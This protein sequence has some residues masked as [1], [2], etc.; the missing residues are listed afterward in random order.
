APASKLYCYEQWLKEEVHLLGAAALELQHLYRAM[1]F[2]EANKDAIERA[3]YFRMADLLNLDVE[4]IFYDTTSLHFEVDDEDRGQG[5]RDEV[6]GSLA[7]G[8][9]TYPA[10]RK[11][12]HSKNGRFDAPQIV[13]GLA[14]TRDGFPVRHWIFPG[15]TVDVTTVERVKQD[16]R[17]WVIGAEPRAASRSGG[18]AAAADEVGEAGHRRGAGGT[19]PGAEIVPEREAELLAGLAEAEEGVAAVA[20]GVGLGA[21]ADL[22]FG[23]LA[24]DVILR[25]VGVQRDLRVV[26]HHQELGLVGVQPLEQAVEGGKAGG[27]QEE[28]DAVEARPH[29]AAAA[30]RRC[31][32]IGLEVG[33]VPPDQ[34]ADMLLG[35]ALLVG[36]RLQLVHQALGMDPAQAMLADI[37]LP[38]VVA[39]DDRLVQE[40]VVGHGTPQRALGG[41]AHRVGGHLQSGHAELLKVALPGGVVGK[42]PLLMCGQLLD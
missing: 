13:V 15:N 23:H 19:E 39:D 3:I 11:R 10:L 31:Q 32:A 6:H 30:R 16:L 18:L 40:P 26:E 41:D 12:G 8:R 20:A 17:G 36:E 4:I 29:F 35:G 21:A 9:K 7:A 25:T 24:A 14:V 27:A 37:E 22:A 42:P 34:P 33:V 5:D 1:D 28:E 38:G 2:L